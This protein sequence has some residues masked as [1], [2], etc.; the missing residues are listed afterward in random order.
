[1]MLSEF[2]DNSKF[3]SSCAYFSYKGLSHVGSCLSCSLPFKRLKY[4]NTSL[5]SMCP[6]LFVIHSLHKINEKVMSIP[7]SVLISSLT[8]LNSFDTQI[9]GS[10]LKVSGT[11]NFS[12]YNLYDDRLCG[13]V[14]RVPGYRS[15]GPGSI[16]DATRFSEK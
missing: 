13:L 10:I 11:F 16:L 2:S 15:R 9:F 1:M 12:L 8:Q 7:L 6:Y 5:N 14:V 4:I 3:P